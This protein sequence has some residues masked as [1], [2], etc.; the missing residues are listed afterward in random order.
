[1]GH[2]KLWNRK[3][4]VKKIVKCKDVAICKER[5]CYLQ[6]KTL[7]FVNKDVAFCKQ[8]HFYVQTKTLLFAYK[9]VAICKQIRCFLQTKTLLFAKKDVAMCHVFG[10]KKTKI[11]HCNFTYRTISLNMLVF[12]LLVK[13]YSLLLTFCSEQN[14]RDFSQI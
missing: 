2:R 3:T 13:Q 8:R 12:K 7:L 5:R 1:M 14:V 10:P 6:R 11:V 9:D 4:T